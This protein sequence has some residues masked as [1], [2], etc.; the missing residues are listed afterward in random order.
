M[1]V[2]TKDTSKNIEKEHIKD[3]IGQSLESIKKGRDQKD[4]IIF[5]T[6]KGAIG[7]LIHLT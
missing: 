4:E 7:T 1:I 5:S 3:M 6:A 2:E